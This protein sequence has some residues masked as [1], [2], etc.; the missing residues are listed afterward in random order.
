[1]VCAIR[2]EGDKRLEEPVAKKTGIFRTFLFDTEGAVSVEFSLWVPI[3]FG[4]FVLIADFTYLAMVN[5]SMWEAARN[6]ARSVAIH[7][8]DIASAE[9]SA[10]RSLVGTLDYQIAVVNDAEDVSVR[11]TLPARKGGLVGLVTKPMNFDLVAYI[12][13]PREPV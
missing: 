7:Q 8:S 12:S 10:R 11:I 2:C 3:I 13:M 4:V 1:M 6:A 9:S 5:A